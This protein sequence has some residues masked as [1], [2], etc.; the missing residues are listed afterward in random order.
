MP[1]NQYDTF[2]R[3]APVW[4]VGVGPGDPDLLTIKAF[5][6]LRAAD[7]IFHEGGQVNTD[8]LCNRKNT[9][10]LIDCNGHTPE[11]NA[12]AMTAFVR[13]QKLVARLHTGDPCVFSAAVEESILLKQEAIN[14]QIVPGI[15]A[16]FLGAALAQKSLTTKDRHQ[17]FTITRVPISRPLPGGQSLENICATGGAVAIYLAN[18]NPAAITDQ[19]TKAGIAPEA[20]VLV[21]NST[22]NN[23]ESLAW[24]PLKELASYAKVH[25]QARQLLVI[26]WP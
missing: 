6:L 13:Q 3:K 9:A 19:C 5:N 18:K 10:L 16:V 25:A 24:V 17:A 2:L 11:E 21:V 23:D 15:S 22:G 12:S 20:P 26:I 1:H 7:V 4:F 14:S 8:I